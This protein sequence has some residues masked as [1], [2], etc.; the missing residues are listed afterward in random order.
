[1]IGTAH[2]GTPSASSPPANNPSRIRIRPG[3]AIRAT[4]LTTAKGLA[5]ID[6]ASLRGLRYIEFDA[7]WYGPEGSSSSDPTKPIAGLDLTQVIAYG[8]AKDI[9]VILYVNQIALT[10]PASLFALYEQWGV[11]GLKLGFILE[12]TQAQT[13]WI[14][15]VAEHAAAHH[16]L[17]NLHDDLRPFGQERT[18][19]NWITLEGVRGNENF[20]TATHNV[21]L[22]FGRNIGGPGSLGNTLRFFNDD[23][24]A[25]DIDK[26]SVPDSI[27]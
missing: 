19:P 14:V 5:Y 2:C 13:D 23:A 22:P 24:A 4:T 9:G 7:G 20:P 12:G 6:F 21:T 17:L 25:P 16:L 18:Y 3:K 1:V 27:Q 10:D 11:A 15:S 26:I 8:Q